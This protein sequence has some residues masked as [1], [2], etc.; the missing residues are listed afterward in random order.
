MHNRYEMQKCYVQQ[1]KVNY[2]VSEREDRVTGA[3]IFQAISWDLDVNVLKHKTMKILLEIKR[4]FK[5]VL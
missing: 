2:A 1:D 3:T 5:F 4:Y